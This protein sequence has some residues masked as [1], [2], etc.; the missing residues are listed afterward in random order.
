MGKMNKKWNYEDVKK[1][2]ESFGYKLISKEYI[3]NKTKILIQCDKGHIYETTFNNFKNKKSRCPICNGGIKYTY[4]YIKEYIEGFGYK[5][6]SKEYMN[7]RTKLKVECP[8][9]HIYE[10]TFDNFKQGYRCP[11]CAGNIKYT[12][13]YVKEYIESFGYKLLSKEYVD[14]FDKLKVECPK[15][16]IYE[17]AF[18]NFKY[19]YRCPICN[20]SSGEQEVSRILDMYKV[21]FK[22][23]YKFMDCVDKGVLRFDF[24]LPKYNYCIEFDGKQHFKVSNFNNDEY[25]VALD[26]FESIKRRDNIKDIYCRDNS[27]KLIRIPYWDFKNIEEILVKELNLK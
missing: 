16:H 22:Y 19:G 1:Y 18:N 27:I 15:G 2:I 7:A 10:V 4:E 26:N 24:Y 5:L 6:L 25:S 17:V 14:V 20:Q 21:D 3:N 23:D 12:Y 8:K 11:Y 13:E 9:G